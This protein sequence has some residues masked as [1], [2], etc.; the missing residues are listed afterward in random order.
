MCVFSRA[1]FYSDPKFVKMFVLAPIRRKT[2]SR[3]MRVDLQHIKHYIFPD[4]QAGFPARIS[5]HFSNKKSTQSNSG[6]MRV[7]LQR[8]QNFT[9]FLLWDF[10]PIFQHKNLN[11]SF[12]IH[13]QGADFWVLEPTVQFKESIKS[14]N[15]HSDLIIMCNNSFSIDVFVDN[16]IL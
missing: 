1:P 2:N 9:F 12:P 3:V 5:S 4:F 13:T 15:S 6:V 11:S 8:L 7:H 16:F 10:Q 14:S